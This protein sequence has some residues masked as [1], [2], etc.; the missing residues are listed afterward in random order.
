[1]Q[2]KYTNNIKLENKME[3]K[4]AKKRL[5]KVGEWLNSEHKSFIDLSAMNVE[6]RQLFMK[7]AMR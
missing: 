7:R 1:M 4:E 5:S 2:Q 6:R 3:T